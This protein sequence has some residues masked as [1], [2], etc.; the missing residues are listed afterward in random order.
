MHILVESIKFIFPFIIGA[1]LNKH[2]IIKDI[3]D[4]F[5]DKQIL[6]SICI[7]TTI[8]LRLSTTF[9]FIIQLIYSCLL[10]IL[11]CAQKRPEWINNA[12]QYLGKHSTSIWFIH[13]YFIW[14]L[15]GDILYSLKYP[16]IIFIALI[17]LSLCSAL[18]IDWI[19]AQVQKL[20]FK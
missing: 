17:I 13:A 10:I 8:L 12:L 2:K 11:I 5:K 18:I 16:I 6:V 20:I 14:Y 1:L 9:D 7:I 4:W 15:S 19:N 3:K